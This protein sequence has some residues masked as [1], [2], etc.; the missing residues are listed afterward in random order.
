LD[1]HNSPAFIAMLVQT[2]HPF[3]ESP[4]LRQTRP[5]Q[6]PAAVTDSSSPS[7]SMSLLSSTSTQ[8]PCMHGSIAASMHAEEPEPKPEAGAAGVEEW[9]RCAGRYKSGAR[10]RNGAKYGAFCGHHR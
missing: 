2:P 7:S 4:A 9:V 6:S 3:A 10:C 8:S 5:L 1:V